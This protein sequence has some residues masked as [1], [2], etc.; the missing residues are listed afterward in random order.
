M[1]LRWGT[2]PLPPAGS[3]MQ[4]RRELCDILF[5]EEVVAQSFSIVAHSTYLRRSIFRLLPYD[6]QGFDTLVRCCA[7]LYTNKCEG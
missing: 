5:S 7:L 6:L 4:A 3:A 2:S 1:A